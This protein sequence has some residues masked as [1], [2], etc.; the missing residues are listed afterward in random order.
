MVCR[1]FST[2]HI[3]SRLIIHIL[4][5]IYTIILVGLCYEA[6]RGSRLEVKVAQEKLPFIVTAS[7]RHCFRSYGPLTAVIVIVV[8]GTGGGDLR[9]CI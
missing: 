5:I 8:V 9:V 2:Y 6:A 1:N 4:C 3:F 7:C